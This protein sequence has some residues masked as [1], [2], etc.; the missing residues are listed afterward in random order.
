MIRFEQVS[1]KKKIWIYGVHSAFAA[2]NNPNR[3]IY[4][5]KCISSMKDKIK[6]I[7]PDLKINIVDP[8]TLLKLTKAVHQGIA[9]LAEP[10]KIHKNLNPEIDNHEKAVILDRLEDTQNVGAIIRSMIA[11]NFNAIIVQKS[12]NLEQLSIKSAS[13]AME[14]ISIF[15]V[16]NLSNAVRQLK[17]AD[18]WCVGLD[19]RAKTIYKPN[20]N[21]LCLIIGSES[22]GIK[23][24][25]LKECDELMS[26]KTSANFPV[27]NASVAA[28]IS[29]YIMST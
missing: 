24:S 26:I 20:F 4:E 17:K 2:L 14:E 19:H 13:G 16:S 18:F 12:K 9:V 8:N 3:I 23:S 29:M 28:G 7:R 6:S 21:K 5:I 10:L 1:K 25:I 22:S 15:E 27:L 11:L